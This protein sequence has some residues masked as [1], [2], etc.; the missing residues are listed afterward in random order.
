[1]CVQVLQILFL[2]Y[3]VSVWLITTQI[4]FLVIMWGSSF[5]CCCHHVLLSVPFHGASVLNRVIDSLLSFAAAHILPFPVYSSLSL[6]VFS[7]CLRSL[8][9]C[10]HSPQLSS[11]VVLGLHLLLPSLF[12]RKDFLVILLTSSFCMFGLHHVFFCTVWFTCIFPVLCIRSTM[13]ILSYHI[14]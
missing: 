2:T 9:V 13:M 10:I 12:H 1:M 8:S 14:Q 11:L 5:C 7:D 6:I 4:S 3:C